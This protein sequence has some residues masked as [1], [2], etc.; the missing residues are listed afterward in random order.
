MFLS[1]SLVIACKASLG[2]DNID[3][4]I[5]LQGNSFAAADDDDDDAD[6]NPQ[7]V[8][9]LHFGGGFMKRE[10][11]SSVEEAVEQPRSKKEVC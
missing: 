2:F 7:M 9:D 6:L 3:H 8:H 5:Y 11:R 1:E 10:G 4:L